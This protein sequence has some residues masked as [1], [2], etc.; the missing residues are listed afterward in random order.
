MKRT[1]LAVAVLVAT[2]YPLVTGCHI[3]PVKASWSGRIDPEDTIAQSLTC[4]LDTPI[5]A[6]FFT[7]TATGRQ[8]Q[9]QLKFPGENGVDSPQRRLTII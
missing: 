9:V 3:E 2:A 7:G 6:E 1:A 5:Y 8:Y 4:N